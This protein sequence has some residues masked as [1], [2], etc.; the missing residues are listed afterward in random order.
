MDNSSGLFWTPYHCAHATAPKVYRFVFSL[1]RVNTVN[2]SRLWE[3]FE[4]SF[5]P[6]MKFR[7]T[8]SL[9]NKFDCACFR[10]NSL[11]EK[12]CEGVGAAQFY[13]CLWDCLTSNAAV[14]LPAISF[15]LAHYDRRLSTEDQLHV[16]GTNIDIMVCGLLK[17]IF[18]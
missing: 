11:L 12:V 7:Y 9:S 6:E 15:A 2:V 16:M 4:S 8:A 17:L 3:P 1:W 5:S 14:R 13:G 10:T 18:K